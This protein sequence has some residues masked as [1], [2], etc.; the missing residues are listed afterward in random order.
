MFTTF[1][2]R[3]F[4]LRFWVRSN[5]FHSFDNA[6][7]TIQTSSQLLNIK[8]IVFSN[9]TS[10]M[11]SAALE[12]SEISPMNPEAFLADNVRCNKPSPAIYEVLI[13]HM[14]I[15]EVPPAASQNVWLISE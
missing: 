5:P 6:L 13:S 14:N 9:G 1:S 12:A 11:V 2:N 15:E 10:S 8:L 7:R 4:T 3:S